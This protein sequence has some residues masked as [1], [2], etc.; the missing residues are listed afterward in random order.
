MLNKMSTASALLGAV[1]LLSACGGGSG[2][3]GQGP[4]QNVGPPWM[5]SL[6]HGALS[7]QHLGPTEVVID[8]P[9]VDGIT[10]D[11][12]ITA[13]QNT[14]PTNHGAYGATLI[15]DA[16]P[17]VQH[18]GLVPGEPVYAALG[19]DGELVAWTSFVPNVAGLNGAPRAQA[20][21]DDGVR[22]VGGNFTVVSPVVGFGAAFARTAD[23]P[24]ALAFPEVNGPVDAV[25][26]DGEG[27]WFIGGRFTTVGGQ[28]RA[29]V[30]HMDHLGR[31][32]DW[33]PG[34]TGSAVEALLLHDDVLYLGGQFSAVG[35]VPRQQLAAITR[36]GEVTAW[37]A[38][39]TGNA[40][41]AVRALAL[42][43]GLIYVG[44]NFNAAAGMPRQRLAA[45]DL[46]GALVDWAPV[47]NAQVFA[48]LVHDGVLYV[49]GQFSQVDGASR[50]MLAA[51]NADGAL[52]SWGTAATIG[53]PVK[54]LAAYQGVIY[55]GGE[56]GTLT[57]GSGPGLGAMNTAG[58]ILSWAPA[59]YGNT[60][61]IEALAV[62]DG[63][64][65]AGGRQATGTQPAEP[66]PWMW[67]FDTSGASVPWAA[68]VNGPVNALAVDDTTVYAG[69]NFTGLRGVWR[70]RVAAFGPAGNLLP[71]APVLTGGGTAAGHVNALATQGERIVIGGGF[72]HVN[73]ALQP[74]LTAM[75]RNGDLVS[76]P[77]FSDAIRSLAMVGDQLYAGGEFTVA[78]NSH[79]QP[80]VV[81]ERLARL[82]IGAS[83]LTLADAL[84]AVKE[85][86]VTMMAAAGSTLYFGG[87]FTQVGVSTVPG[88][89]AME[90]GALLDWTSGLPGSLRALATG[91]GRLAVGYAA[92]G[93][94]GMPSFLALYD[95]DGELVNTGLSL[96]QAVL[97]L[98]A[99][100]TTL[101][102]SGDFSQIR[103]DTPRAGLAAVSLHDGTPRP[104]QP[105]LD[106]RP[107]GL[108]VH[109]GTVYAIG[110]FKH[111]E[112]RVR[113]GM[114]AF[115]QAGNL[116]LR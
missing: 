79:D 29:R 100:D 64:I 47:L 77:A 49:G 52:T 9:M 1:L 80:D 68:G 99:D 5:D 35:G 10:Y 109:D 2:S 85:G 110:E 56:F 31:V 70:H 14:D 60:L 101:Y 17:P 54:A 43:D 97:A 69:G 44:G 11:L 116:L 95:G 8:W 90:G 28:S 42:R 66:W 55:I 34:V 115:D 36:T 41:V 65:Y 114:A 40:S 87:S 18:A 50:G 25:L 82:N 93:S 53:N 7:V 74:R 61:G 108:A 83:A 23:A 27:G 26:S 32:T 94:A 91:N 67:A 24:H 19:I 46:E 58:E 37:G 96:N 38:S 105:V 22:F 75:E 104:W 30:A 92:H 33:N 57:T 48:L 15:P 86:A 20:V 62:R 39:V 59:P 72:T 84:P 13:E 98:A 4:G 71:W 112:G 78:N 88:L 51:F 76:A 111:A 21:A 106:R 63:V 16:Q 113:A 3:S 6:H 81:R 89:A 102:L 103:G 73:G 45:F 107:D 12:Y